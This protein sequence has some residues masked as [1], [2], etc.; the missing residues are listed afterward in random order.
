M[1]IV[2]IP[3][4]YFCLNIDCPLPLPLP[5]VA[6]EGGKCGWQGEQAGARGEGERERGGETQINIFCTCVSYGQ[7]SLFVL[8]SLSFGSFDLLHLF[9]YYH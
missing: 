1:A 6:F 3:T 9:W 2:Y 8:I 7:E 5:S 4:S